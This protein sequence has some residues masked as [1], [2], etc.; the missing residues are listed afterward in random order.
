MLLKKTPQRSVRKILGDITNTV[1]RASV[2]RVLRYDLKLTPYTFVCYAT[3]QGSDID[4]RLRF[5]HWMNENLDIVN[6]LW[7]SDESHF[8]LDAAVNKK[9]SRHWGTEKPNYYLEKTLHSERVTVWAA[10]SSQCVIGPFFLKM[11]TEALKPS[12]AYGT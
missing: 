5:S 1:S 2:H 11:K 3:S 9:N 7:F 12:I 10:M 6:V 8:Y 4:S